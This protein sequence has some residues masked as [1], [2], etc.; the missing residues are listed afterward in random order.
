MKLSDIKPIL[1][2]TEIQIV[3][4]AVGADFG[5]IIRSGIEA[6][7]DQFKNTLVKQVTPKLKAWALE[8]STKMHTLRDF[9]TDDVKY[10]T[11]HKI[12]NNTEEA[13]RSIISHVMSKRLGMSAPPR[14]Q[15]PAM[16]RDEEDKLDDVLAG[17]TL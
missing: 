2:P 15:Q 3:S 1:T 17:I 16:S 6:P 12:I 4:E 13:A 5:R 11:L 10:Q 7:F 8:M 14:S 9:D